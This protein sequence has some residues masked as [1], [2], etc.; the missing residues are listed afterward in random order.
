MSA[1][2]DPSRV[3]DAIKVIVGTA[4]LLAIV[5]IVQALVGLVTS[6]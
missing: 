5:A 3:G 4:V 1:G 6:G 2:P